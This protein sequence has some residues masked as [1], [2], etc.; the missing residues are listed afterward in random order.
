M[1]GPLRVPATERIQHLLLEA[2]SRQLRDE[3]Q[4][5]PYVDIPSAL[6]LAH[7]RL[8][9][10]NRFVIPPAKRLQLVSPFHYAFVRFV[11]HYRNQLG[12]NLFAKE[13]R[14][15]ELDQLLDFIQ[16]LAFAYKHIIRDTLA[17]NKRPAGFA[18]VLYMAMLYQ[19]YHGLISYNRSRM[20][21]RFHWREFHYL[22][23]LA[24]GINQEHLLVTDPAGGEGSVVSLY[25]QSILLGLACPYTLRAED[26]WRTH[27]YCARFAPLVQLEPAQSPDALADSY[28]VTAECRHPAHIPGASPEPGTQAWLL[29]LSPL[30][31]KVCRH[32]A[33]IRAGEVPRVSA[34]QQL[35]RRRASQLL[36]TLYQNWSRNTQRLAPRREIDEQIGLVW[37]LETICGMLDPTQRRRSGAPEPTQGRDK[38]AWCRGND[39]SDSGIRVRLTGPPDQFPDPGQVVALIRQRP[40]GKVLELGL[41]RWAAISN[42]D[43]PQ[44]GILRLVGNVNPVSLRAGEEQATERNALLIVQRAAGNRLSPRLLAPASLLKRHGEITLTSPDHHQPLL[45]QLQEPLQSTHHVELFAIRLLEE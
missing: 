1:N 29:D 19:Y 43:A 32:L 45:A 6:A 35:P 11:D 27:E 13:I 15:E 30:L 12:G 24:D 20:L 37:G 16:E 3:I 31:D 26:Q 18:T 38:R 44:C 21:K 4:D 36:E 23:F 42:D 34:L 5:L 41:V 39:E 33:A 10:F 17:R 7:R 22:Y 2:D 14:S 28:F 40:R 25:K 8:H 9:G